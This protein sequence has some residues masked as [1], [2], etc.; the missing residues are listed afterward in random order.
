MALSVWPPP[1]T[2]RRLLAASPLPPHQADLTFE[3]D[4]DHWTVDLALA[5][6]RPDGLVRHRYADA[7]AGD[8]LAA[9]ID[10]VALCACA[11]AGVAGHTVWQGRDGPFRFRPCDDPLAVL[12]T[13]VRLYAQGMAAPLYFFPRTAWAWLRPGG[14]LS[15]A[16]QAW[17]VST[18]RP[19]AEQGDAA[20][21]LALR[22][23]PDPLRDGLP[24][25]EAAARAVFEPLLQ[26]L[27]DPRFGDREGSAP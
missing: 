15:K 18:R 20:H 13:L 27:D 6:L 25:F 3:L 16:G 26:C 10:H 19:Y 12:Q 4:G 21:R 24:R 11:P 23:L 17:T 14:S 22:G 5:D 7:G 2:K 8:Y 9:W 1:C